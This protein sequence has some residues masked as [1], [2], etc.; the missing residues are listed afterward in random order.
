MGLT[1]MSVA[2]NFISTTPRSGTN[3]E[4]MVLPPEYPV[5]MVQ[6]ENKSFQLNAQENDAE[7]DRIENS[8]LFFIYSSAFQKY[9]Q[10]LLKCVKHVF[11]LLSCLDMQQ[12]DLFIGY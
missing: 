6:M 7:K 8:E 1:A 9:G 4:K 10:G 2:L 5:P 3:R 11:I 12:P